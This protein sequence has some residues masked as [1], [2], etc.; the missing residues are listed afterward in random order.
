MEGLGL[1]RV[2]KNRAETIDIGGVSICIISYDDLI[3]NKRAVNRKSDQADID[4]L[5]KIR[6]RN[7]SKE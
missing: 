6:K 5:G 3:A 1:F 7:T 4:E 2:S